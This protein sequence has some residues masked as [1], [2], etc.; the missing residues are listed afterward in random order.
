MG[1]T[2]KLQGEENILKKGKEAE[3]AGGKK[4]GRGGLQTV[5]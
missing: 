1:A 5:C 2:G 4:N 3:E